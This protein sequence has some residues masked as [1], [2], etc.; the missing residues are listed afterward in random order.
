MNGRFTASLMYLND[1][2]ARYGPD[3]RHWARPPV[4]ERDA[5]AWRSLAE[6]YHAILQREDLPAISA[7]LH[8]GQSVRASPSG[9]PGAESSHHSSA[10]ILAI[11]RKRNITSPPS[12]QPA[13]PATVEPPETDDGSVDRAHVE[14]VLRLLRALG[15]A[16]VKPFDSPVL[17]FLP[18]GDYAALRRQTPGRLRYLLRHARRLR[19]LPNQ[20]RLCDL[21]QHESPVRF[22]RLAALADLIRRRNDHEMITQW[23]DASDP[24]TDRSAALIAGMMRMMDELEIF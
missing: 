21:T 2:A 20:A 15:K 24:R 1:V 4:L 8:E 3:W 22:N 11:G 23:L 19:L 6:A 14:N 13:S 5:V 17:R 9:R 12:R 16:G 18:P 7:W 10:A